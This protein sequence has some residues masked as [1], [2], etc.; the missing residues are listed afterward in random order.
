MQVTAHMMCN[1]QPHTALSLCSSHPAYM[2]TNLTPTLRL[3]YLPRFVES[4]P[5]PLPLCIRTGSRLHLWR[6][7]QF[8]LPVPSASRNMFCNYV[9]WSRDYPDKHCP[10]SDKVPSSETDSSTHSVPE[11]SGQS[12]V[13]QEFLYMPRR[14]FYRFKIGVSSFLCCLKYAA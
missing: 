7:P 1:Q 10:N 9:P 11:A 5:L 12:P 2:W 14:C 3:S 8:Q 6:S 13:S 4:V